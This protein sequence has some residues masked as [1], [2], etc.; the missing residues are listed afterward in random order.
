M[1]II[2]ALLLLIGPTFGSSGTTAE[3]EELW[4]V[5]LNAQPDWPLVDAIPELGLGLVR[6]K[7]GPLEHGRI[8][9]IGPVGV[10]LPAGVPTTASDPLLP[11]QY[12]IEQVGFA[13]AWTST[14]GED[15]LVAVLDS[16][17]DGTHPDLDPRRIEKFGSV[18]VEEY[19]DACGHGTA[20][21]GALMA[22]AGNG[23][24]IAGA[25]SEVRILPVKVLE[26]TCHGNTFDLAKGIVL[27]T[28]AGA[29]IISLSL[30]AGAPDSTVPLELDAAI[31]FADARGVLIIA[32]AGNTGGEGVSPPAND[33]RVL[34]VGCT[35]HSLTRCTVSSYGDG[36]DI[37]APGDSIITTRA[38]GEY[39]Y[40]TGTS[41]SVPYVVAT[42][43]L[44]LSFYGTSCPLALKAH[45]AATAQ[46][47]GPAAVGLGV[48]LVDAGEALSRAPNSEVCRVQGGA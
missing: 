46:P 30:T 2:F 43:A 29:D 14:R 6:G 7:P 45:L 12:A 38:G 23:I 27:A 31:R 19:T 25:A 10:T 42:A 1:R 28:L 15:V 8:G 32:A 18:R 37:A 16:G 13:E 33:P 48:G 5:A 44:V 21:T 11:D 22:T 3:A 40:Y 9:W 47:L 36:V 41:L 4:L 35:D 26:E 20:V 17:V 34:A 24:G 39:G